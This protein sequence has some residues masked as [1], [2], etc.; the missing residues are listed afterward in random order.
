MSNYNNGDP[1]IYLMTENSKLK[2]LLQRALPEIQERVRGLN[3]C[4]PG[5]DVLLHLHR[6]ERLLVEIEHALEDW[7]TDDPS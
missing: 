3:N 5:V 4:W 6:N 2:D 7:E 1:I